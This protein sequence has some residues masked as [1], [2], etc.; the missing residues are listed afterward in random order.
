V[1]ME[2]N[3]S[4]KSEIY[5]KHICKYYNVTPVQI[6]YVNKILKKE[7]VILVSNVPE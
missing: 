2:N 1:E 3:G 6:L 7:N 4:G 5:C